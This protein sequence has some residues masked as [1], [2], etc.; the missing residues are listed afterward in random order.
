MR[1]ETTPSISVPDSLPFLKSLSWFDVDYRNLSLIEMLRRYES[2]WRHKG[3][4]S[5]P[6][7]REAEFIKALVARFGSILDVQA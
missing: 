5:E 4:L 3:V 6:S 2:G 1:T 7:P